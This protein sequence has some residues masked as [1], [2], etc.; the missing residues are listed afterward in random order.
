MD[1][2]LLICTSSNY[3]TAVDVN[4]EGDCDRISFDGNEQMKVKT[5]E[6]VKEFCAQILN[7]YNISSFTDIPIDIKI[8]LIS[9]YSELIIELYEIVKKS[10]NVNL[11]AVK[12]ILPIWLLKKCVVKP[13]GV[14]DV[15]CLK[16][17]FTLGIDDNYVVSYEEKR[18]GKNIVINPEDFVLLY[19]FECS[20][21]LSDEEEKK[22]LEAKY[23]ELEMKTEQ[24]FSKCKELYDD[25][26]SKYK[27]LEDK[28]AREVEQK[29]KYLQEKRI[30]VW[31]DKKKLRMSNSSNSMFI[32][33][34]NVGTMMRAFAN[35]YSVEPEKPVYKCKWLKK[36]GDI[37]S[38]KENLL[39]IIECYEKSNSA[40]VETGRKCKIKATMAGR[41]FFLAKD[42]QWLENNAPVALMSDPSENKQTLMEWY[43]AMK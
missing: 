9:D 11:I 38:E 18:T 35:V 23:K 13:G 2:K 33:S 6:D 19:R 20:N 26:Q 42:N 12:S 4:N 15:E 17:V 21:L 22:E 37:V 41:V 39:E 32:S 8:V 34:G 40:N 31:F 30:I 1:Y 24:E 28:Y 7:Y 16:E 36:D 27:E 10:S 14:I 43:K 29:E 5:V 25:L 3:W